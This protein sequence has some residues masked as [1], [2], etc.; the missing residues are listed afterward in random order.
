MKQAHGSVA[1]ACFA[2]SAFIVA[3]FSGLAA[4]NPLNTILLRAIFAMILCYPVGAIAGR[5]FHWVA[6]QCEGSSH[7]RMAATEGDGADRAV[8]PDAAA[9]PPATSAV[10]NKPQRVPVAQ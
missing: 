10:E 9:P 8:E 3:L 5:V 1:A 6:E 2:L 4:D 7:D